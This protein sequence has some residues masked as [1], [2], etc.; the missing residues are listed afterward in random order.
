MRGEGDSLPSFG[1][2]SRLVKNGSQLVEETCRVGG[3]YGRAIEKIVYWL[4]QARN[5]AENEQQQ[6][7]IDLLCQYYTTG[8]LTLFDQYSIEWLKEQEGRVDFINGFIEVYGDPLGLKGT[9]EGLVEYK[10]PIATQRTQTISKTH[11]GLKITRL[12]TRVSASRRLKA[13]QPMLSAQPCS[14]VTNTRHQ[15]SASICQM[16]T[17]YAPVTAQRA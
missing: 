16:P 9:W 6:K 15:P 11:S 14:A 3:R 1:L 5:E 8:D 2:N 4:Q 12:S 13:L 10:D 17:G 7:V